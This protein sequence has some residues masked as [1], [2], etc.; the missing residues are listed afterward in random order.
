MSDGIPAGF[1][2]L[3]PR[4]GDFFD[5][6]GPVYLRHDGDDMTLGFR[7]ELRHCNPLRVAHGGM[8]VAMVD[9]L[10]GRV[11]WQLGKPAVTVSLTCDF[12]SAARLG[13]WVEVRCQIGRASCRERV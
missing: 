3:P 5:A 7:L 12:L 13:A 11:I 10:M 1:V 9:D 6:N 4:G 2:A 8:L